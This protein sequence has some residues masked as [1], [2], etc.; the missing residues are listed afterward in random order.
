MI[1]GS[2]PV[3]DIVFDG[4]CGVEDVSEVQEGVNLLQSIPVDD[5][6]S[7]DCTTPRRWLK[8]GLGLL[9]VGIHFGA[10]LCTHEGVREDL[11][12]VRGSC[13]VVRLLEFTDRGYRCP[14][15]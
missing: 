9:R 11:R 14:G 12:G 7:M 2:D 1:G 13:V 4:C 5:D 15:G 8:E 3:R 10:L 6:V